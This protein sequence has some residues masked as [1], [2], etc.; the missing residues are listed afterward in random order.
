MISAAGCGLGATCYLRYPRYP[1]LN[2]IWRWL[3]DKGL[4][5]TEEIAR[6]GSAPALAIKSAWIWVC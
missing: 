6:L 2:K 5:L 1:W 4:R 3:Q